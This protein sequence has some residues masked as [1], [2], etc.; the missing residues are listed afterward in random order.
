MFNKKGTYH[1]GDSGEPT[2]CPAK[3][4]CRIGGIHG[5]YET[6]LK[7]AEKQNEEHYSPFV[8][9]SRKEITENPF[10]GISLDNPGKIVVIEGEEPEETPESA[11]TGI[12]LVEPHSNPFENIMV[13]TNDEIF[14]KF[15]SVLISAAETSKQNRNVERAKKVRSLSNLFAKSS[16]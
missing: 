3:I 8:K 5:D 13:K 16:H 10:T 12:Q 11:F 6:V 15:D 14:K 1:I 9:V 4:K 7:A 2:L